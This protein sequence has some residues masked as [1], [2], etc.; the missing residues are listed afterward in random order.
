MP[1][2]IGKSEK[3]KK[4]LDRLDRWQIPVVDIIM[5]LFLSGS[6]MGYGRCLWS[7]GRG[8]GRE[9]G[10]ETREGGRES[11]GRRP[12]EMSRNSLRNWACWLRGGILK[13]VISSLISRQTARS[14][15]TV[16]VISLTHTDYLFSSL[17]CREFLACA[18]RY[19]LPLGDFPN[20]DQYRKMLRE[21][22]SKGRKCVMGNTPVGVKY[23]IWHDYMK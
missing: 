17:L 2:V 21:V 3:Q 15:I 20:V 23:E 4:L 13:K 5:C 19:N 16:I 10:I 18:R 8:R 14:L 6:D 9:R 11:N 12:R 1:Y 7:W 22:R